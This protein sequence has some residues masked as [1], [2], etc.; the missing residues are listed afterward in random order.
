MSVGM[1]QRTETEIRLI[2]YNDADGP[3]LGS[4]NALAVLSVL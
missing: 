4:L 1:M 2:K 3:K